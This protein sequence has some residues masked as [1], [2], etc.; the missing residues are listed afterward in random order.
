MAAKINKYRGGE[1]WG[2]MTLEM[3]AQRHSLA[4]IKLNAAKRRNK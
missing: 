2:S 3:K 4:Q 1:K